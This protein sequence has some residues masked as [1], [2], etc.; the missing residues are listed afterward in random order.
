V[1]DDSRVPVAGA[2]VK[3]ATSF[4]YTTCC[5]CGTATSTVQADSL[6]RY[7]ATLE[8]PP[9]I[10]PVRAFE[11]SIDKAG[12]ERTH[13]YIEMTG[14]ATVRNLRVRPLVIIPVGESALTDIEID[15]E[16][17]LC[18]F[19]LEYACRMFRLRSSVPGYVAVDLGGVS[20]NQASLLTGD[21]FF[22]YGRTAVSLS[23]PISDSATPE[24]FVLVDWTSVRPTPQRISLT[25]ALQ[26]SR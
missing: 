6:G 15:A 11:A 8:L 12:F 22:P 1:V 24:F 13:Q 2:Q 10:G 17:S 14:N 5:R 20:R 19:E 25:T 18:G 3:V 26:P 9:A 7:D 4:C 16:D 21:P 23:L